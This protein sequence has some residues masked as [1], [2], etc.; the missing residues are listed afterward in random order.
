MTLSIGTNIKKLR[1]QY[2]ITQEQ[3]AEYLGVT[4]QAVSRWE[5]GNGYP[6]IETLPALAGY[7]KV[8]IENLLGVDL[9]Q[10]EQ[11]KLAAEI[12]QLMQNGSLKEALSKGRLATQKYP[13]NSKII[14]SYVSVI[15]VYTSPKGTP[16]PEDEK[17][18]LVEEGLVLLQRVINS[19]DDAM[20]LPTLLL[21]A[22][23]LGI[24][25]RLDEA[26]QAAGSLPHINFS[27]DFVMPRYLK[28]KEKE[29]FIISILPNL[30]ANMGDLI[31]CLEQSYLDNQRTDSKL[32]L[33]GY[34]Y[35]VSERILAMWNATYGNR[36]ENIERK[37]AQ[38]IYLLIHVIVVKHA[39][40]AGDIDKSLRY[41]EEM[42]ESAAA[43]CNSNET[44]AECNPNELIKGM[45]SFFM[46]M[47]LKDEDI[48][49]HNIAYILYYYYY[50]DGFFKALENN[51][52]AIDLFEKLKTLAR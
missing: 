30:L 41:L 22:T 7:F 20:K 3:L 32:T 18:D 12:V 44:P 49:S 19:N 5:S 6:D 27:R 35:D 2:N 16:V 48:Q 23:L 28:K 38:I 13:T 36:P 50:K 34:N 42:I 40:E 47:D 39:S 4:A 46:E 1:T 21:K 37:R 45:L 29:N 8:S 31:A 33:F 9:T 10:E 24:V 51:P 43:V 11:E 52:A 25:G 15:I 26:A 17:N 14:L